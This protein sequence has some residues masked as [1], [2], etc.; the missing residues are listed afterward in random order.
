MFNAIDSDGCNSNSL[1][2]PCYG[3]SSSLLNVMPFDGLRTPLPNVV[4]VVLVIED[5]F[6]SLS[7]FENVL[8][9]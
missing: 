3:K 1:V 6:L 2:I 9:P 7:T 5:A 8:V 4:Y